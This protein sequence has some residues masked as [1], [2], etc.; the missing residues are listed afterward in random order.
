MST[1]RLKDRLAAVLAGA[2]FLAVPVLALLFLSP[3]VLG[4]VLADTQAV[5]DNPA[6][7]VSDGLVRLS[8]AMSKEAGVQ[9]EQGE[10]RDWTE[11]ASPWD[12]FGFSPWQGWN[13]WNNGWGFGGF[14]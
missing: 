3:V 10:L 7:S 8:P 11:T 14:G 12:M 13:R 6:A 9:S 4:S 1:R 5:V 2:V